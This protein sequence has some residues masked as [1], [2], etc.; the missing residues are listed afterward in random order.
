MTVV[1]V[2]VG[3]VALGQEVEPNKQG[4]TQVPSWVSDS[5]HI[6]LERELAIQKLYYFMESD[7]LRQRDDVAWEMVVALNGA[8]LPKEPRSQSNKRYVGLLQTQIESWKTSEIRAKIRVEIAKRDARTRQMEKRL[9]K[10]AAELAELAD[11]AQGTEVAAS[12]LDAIRAAGYVVVDGH[13]L[14][15][16]EANPPLGIRR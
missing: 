8:G 10:I 6:P 1:L 7:F 13:V 16:S 15:E 3:G 9:T 4:A 14:T 11:D 5:I 12:A 2:G